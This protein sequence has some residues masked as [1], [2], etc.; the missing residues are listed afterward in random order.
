MLA[1]IIKIGN[2][3]GVRLP[4]AALLESGLGPNV[5]IAVKKGEIRLIAPAGSDELSGLALPTLSTDWGRPEEEKA[6]SSL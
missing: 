6:W 2:S 4:K 3:R 1:S 5:E